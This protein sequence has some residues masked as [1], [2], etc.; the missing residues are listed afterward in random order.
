MN[1]ITDVGKN[2]QSLRKQKKLTQEKLGERAG[3]DPKYIS[4]LELGYRN[5]TLT[6]LQK[7]AKGLGVEPYELFIFI[8][9]YQEQQKTRIV[10]AI[11]SAIKRADVK[12]LNICLDL[13]TKI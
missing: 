7:I 12:T 11:T 3:I 6:T 10:K 4:A 13:L 1:L 2:I 8:T 9:P 5:P